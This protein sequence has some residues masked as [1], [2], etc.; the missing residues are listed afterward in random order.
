[1][2]SGILLSLENFQALLQINMRERELGTSTSNLS[3]AG[4]KASAMGIAAFLLGVLGFAPG[5]RAT[6]LEQAKAEIQERIAKSGADVAIAFRTLDGREEWLLHPDEEF[7]AAS[8]MKIPVMIELFHQ[9]REGKIKLDERLVIHNEFHSIV[10]GS[11]YHLDSGDDSEFTLYKDEG[12]SRPISDLLEK[13][14]TESSNLATDLLIQKL[15]VENIRATVQALNAD[16]MHVLRGVEDDKAYEKGMNNTTTARGLMVLLQAIADG[17]AVD[18]AASK[19]MIAI[20]E[21]QKFNEAI[22]AG[23]PPG[24]VVAHKTGEITKIHHDAAIVFAKRPFILVIL[25]R[26]IEDRNASSA[27]MADITRTLY[28]AIQ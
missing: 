25:V 24:T 2:E 16:G 7:H 15:G 8:T 11:V 20:L 14:I 13:M 23:L 5:S 6:T 1:M 12:Q 22:P 27:L 26:G 3:S 10:D 28:S 17:K 9:V 18:P 21:R 4:K 19:D